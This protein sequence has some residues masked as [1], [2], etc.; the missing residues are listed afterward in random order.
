MAAISYTVPL[1]QKRSPSAPRE[2]HA[3]KSR[4]FQML[5]A[6]KTNFPHGDCNELASV[7]TFPRGDFNFPRAILF[8]RGDANLPLGVIQPSP[9]GNTAFPFPSSGEVQLSVICGET[10]LSPGDLPAGSRENAGTRRA[11]GAGFQRGTRAY[12]CRA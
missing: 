11:T 4:A 2:V 5:H 3:R 1:S 9:R 8:P 6:G 10:Q 12:L 7:L